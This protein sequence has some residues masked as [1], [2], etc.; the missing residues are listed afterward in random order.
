MDKKD[1]TSTWVVVR[2]FDRKEMEVSAFLQQ[3]GYQ[4]FIPMTYR[5]KPVAGEE[6]PRKVLAPVIHNYIFM[7][8][9]ADEATLRSM[10]AEC[11]VP[12]HLMKNRGSDTL[13]EI[14]DRDMVEFRLLCD[15]D[16]SRTPSDFIDAS[17]GEALPGKEVEVVHGQ[18]K[19]I[20]GKLHKKNQKYWFVK[21]VGVVSV[22]IRISRWYCK[23]I[24]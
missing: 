24:E 4:H 19:G 15:P 12:V 13:S 21:T 6:K 11:R 7:P 5:E 20:R 8:K 3:K 2:T 14:A 9:S 22:M 1:A 16:Y 23:V 10:L 18:F 17:E